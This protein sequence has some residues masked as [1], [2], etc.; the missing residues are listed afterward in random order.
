MFCEEPYPKV[1]KR[2]IK[3]LTMMSHILTNL[4]HAITNF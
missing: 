2:D 3:G 4:L 1:Q